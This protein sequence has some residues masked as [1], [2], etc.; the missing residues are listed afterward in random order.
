MTTDNGMEN[1]GSKLRHDSS[2]L[3]EGPDKKWENPESVI[4]CRGGKNLLLRKSSH[5]YYAALL[6]AY[7]T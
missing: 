6:A 2:I 1:A 4:Y 5:H 3:P 7:A